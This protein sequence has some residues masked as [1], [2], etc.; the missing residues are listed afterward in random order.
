ML[1]S[2]LLRFLFVEPLC[3]C[4]YRFS[5]DS[6]ASLLC[7]GMQKLWDKISTIQKQLQKMTRPLVK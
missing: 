6:T 3:V 2:M 4:R 5:H 1:I 7:L